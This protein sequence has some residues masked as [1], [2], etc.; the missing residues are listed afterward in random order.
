MI[1]YRTSLFLYE[2][3]E[4]EP[5][6]IIV[7][8][9]AT[10]FRFG[11]QVSKRLLHRLLMEYAEGELV[12]PE[13]RRVAWEKNRQVDTSECKGLGIDWIEVSRGE[14][15]HGKLKP[16]KRIDVAN[17]SAYERIRARLG[18][19]E[20]LR[21]AARYGKAK[22]VEKAIKRVIESFWKWLAR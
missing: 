7:F 1:L 9:R 15:K 13:E 4:N 8:W 12:E 18:Y 21:E 10:V 11:K 20:F 2:V 3:V 19:S 17:Y 14:R 22:R 6:P 16:E 5:T